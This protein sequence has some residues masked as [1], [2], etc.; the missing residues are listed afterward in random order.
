MR[1]SGLSA[2]DG[3]PLPQ[4]PSAT[5]GPLHASS[6]RAGTRGR[7]HLRGAR[8]R[9]AGDPV[10]RLARCRRRRRQPGAIVLAS[11][12]QG[13]PR[14]PGRARA[15]AEPEPRRFTLVM[16]GDLLWH[17]TVWQ[18]AAADARGGAAYDFD[19]MFADVKPLIERR[20]PRAVPRGGAVRGAGRAVA[21]L[22]GLRRAAGDRALDRLDGLGRLHDGLQPRPRPG[23]RR[24]G[25]HR[26]LLESVG[27]RHV[28]TFRTARRAPAARRPDD[29][30][31]RAGGRGRRDVRA[32]RLPAPRGPRVVGLHARRPGP[33]AAGAG[34]AA[35]RGR[36]GGRAPAR[37]LRV[38]RAAQPRAGRGRRAAD[39]VAPRRPG[40]RRARAHASSRS[41]GSTGSG[42]STAW[43]TWSPAGGRP[44]GDLPRHPGPLH[45]RRAAGRRVRRPPGGVRP[46]SAGTRPRP[47]TRSGCAASTS[48]VTGPPCCR[49]GRR[50]RP[51]RDAWTSRGGGIVR[52]LR[53]VA[54]PRGRSERHG[55]SRPGQL[56][57]D[58]SGPDPA[59]TH[60]L[61]D[62][63]DVVAAGGH[64]HRGDTGRGG[65]VGERPGQV[66]GDAA[67]ALGREDADADD[68]GDLAARVVAAA[69]DRAELGVERAERDRPTGRG[70]DRGQVA[71]VGLGLG[72]LGV[73]LGDRR[74][75]GLGVVLVEADVDGGLHEP[76]G[77]R[78]PARGGVRRPGSAA[79]P[80][81]RRGRAAGSR[82][83]RTRPRPRPRA[84]T[85]WCRAP[86]RST[87][88][89]PELAEPREHRRHLG[90]GHLGGQ[91]EP[92]PRVVG[93]AA[94]GHEDRERPVLLD[95]RVRARRLVVV[96]LE[97]GQSTSRNLTLDASPPFT[98][99]IETMSPL[100]FSVPNTV[101]MTLKTSF[102]LPVSAFAD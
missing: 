4:S 47:A 55:L 87:A 56:L 14:S 62:P 91:A 3:R 101:I 37:R 52:D 72:H 69:A 79:R 68:L 39:P 7:R 102:P 90:G 1:A 29:R 53:H 8:R 58:A 36:R 86:T 35:G 49:R 9:G 59:E 6:H 92:R 34:R 45:F 5:S 71:D 54:E 100:D 75:A 66:A 82:R 98:V 42:S 76:R 2:L 85:A 18:S 13:R 70:Q 27:V 64:E 60:A 81:R 33:A 24:A 61:V 10:R 22:P 23:L 20:R 17:D 16:G 67:A 44:A 89:T 25:A 73:P 88:G 46:R 41:R 30:V 11:G 21:E 50:Q 65:V 43:A 94:A 40:A 84:A 32:Q 93:P 51:G 80:G 26:R 96:G 77:R 78:R 74:G 12:V 99:T 38:R 28:G 97:P 31:R 57:D 48:P 19:P 15:A 95:V 83:P 63:G